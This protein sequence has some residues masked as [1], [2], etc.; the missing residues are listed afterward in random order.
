[1]SDGMHL[2]LF[3]REAMVNFYLD[4]RIVRMYW[5]RLQDEMIHV[6]AQAQAQA[7]ADSNQRMVNYDDMANLSKINGFFNSLFPM[8]SW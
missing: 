4:Y 6:L 1:M 2:V 5:L 7:Q 3:D 8:R